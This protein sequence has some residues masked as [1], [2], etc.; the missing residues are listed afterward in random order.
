MFDLKNLGDM[1]KLAGEAKELQREQQ[2]S[3]ERKM[4]LLSKISQQLDE[5]LT[6]LRKRS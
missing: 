6:E 2:K 4:Q 3:E 5:I 1:A